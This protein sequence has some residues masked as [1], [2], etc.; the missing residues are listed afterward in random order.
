[1]YLCALQLA[2]GAGAILNKTCAESQIGARRACASGFAMW[3]EI[4]LTCFTVLVP[5][6]EGD[7]PNH[8][9]PGHACPECGGGA[10]TLRKWILKIFLP[11]KYRII[12]SGS[13]L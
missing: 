3:T 12:S 5:P 2:M 7:Q 8:R 9:L 1:M 4:L 11:P 10:L 6:G 13:L